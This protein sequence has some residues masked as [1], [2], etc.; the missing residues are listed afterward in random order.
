MENFTTFTTL[1]NIY[2]Q[3]QEQQQQAASI[4]LAKT[5]EESI[6]LNNNAVSYLLKG[7]H[8]FALQTFQES[9]SK[10]LSF[11]ETVLRQSI[12]QQ[13]ETQ[14]NA[15]TSNKER[16]VLEPAQMLSVNVPS[17][18]YYNH[19]DNPIESDASF[20]D[21]FQFFNRAMLLQDHEDYML[22]LVNS[23]KKRSRTMATIL[24]N[25]AICYHLQGL[26]TGIG[27]AYS[28][29]LNFYG[30]AYSTIEQSSQQYG[31]QDALLLV[32]AL[33]NNMGHIHNIA[34]VNSEKT[35]QCIYW[36]QSTFRTPGIKTILS[37]EDYHFFF[38]YIS[39][40]SQ[41]QLLIAPTA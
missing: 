10:F 29:A 3:Q 33:F 30:Q 19:S 39:V 21:I 1:Y 5:V 38:Q 14:D 32:L 16:F 37:I 2:Q 7:E 23:P 20:E 4:M 41:K 8:G 6:E 15:T 27:Q 35:R 24:Y 12:I 17:S 22:S 26:H 25:I 13:D 11:Q 9:L 40:S 31:F 28:H 36:M 18:Y 34:L